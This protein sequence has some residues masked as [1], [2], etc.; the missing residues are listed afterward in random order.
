MIKT[1]KSADRIPEPGL[2]AINMTVKAI[3][4]MHTEAIL[5]IVNAYVLAL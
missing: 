4:L 3:T 1:T 2:A 5:K